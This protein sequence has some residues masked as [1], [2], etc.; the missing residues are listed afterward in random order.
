VGI[1]YNF[2]H[3]HGHIDDFSEVLAQMKPYL[4]CLNLNGM[5][6]SG[7]PKILPIGRGQH[8][9]QMLKAVLA[10]GYDGPIGILDHRNELDAEL[11][12]RENLEGLD[13]LVGELGD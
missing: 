11:S 9:K 13:K 6:R 4:L 2:H 12:L 10:V 7:E 3:G 1:V 5:N 8:E